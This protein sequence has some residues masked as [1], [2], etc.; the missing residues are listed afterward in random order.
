VLRRKIDRPAFNDNDRTLLGV[1]ANARPRLRRTGWIVTWG[2][3][4]GPHPFR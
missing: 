4:A 1:I 3:L 2:H